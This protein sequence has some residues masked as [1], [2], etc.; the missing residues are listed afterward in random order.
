LDESA[1]L[2]DPGL[3]LTEKESVRMAIPGDNYVLRLREKDGT[4]IHM[5]VLDL[6]HTGPTER[7][8]LVEWAYGP[9]A[10]VDV[11]GFSILR[12]DPLGKI[13]GQ[14]AKTL[15]SFPGLECGNFELET[16]T[17]LP[18]IDGFLL[19][20]TAKNIFNGVQ[21]PFAMRMNNAGDV[22]WARKY[23]ADVGHPTT[24]KI[25]SMV[26]LEKPNF[27][28]S[29]LSSDDET[30]LFQIDGSTGDVTSSRLMSSL[31]IRRLR[32]TSLGVLAVGET[33][34]LLSPE[35]A[36]L[37]LDS[38]TATPIWL[39]TSTWEKP[40]PDSG[41]RWLDIAEGKDVLLVVGN[42]VGHVNEISPWMAFLD[43]NSLPTPADIIKVIVPEL[44][45][46]P[47]R[48]RS[49]VNHQD[50]VIPIKEG[51]VNSIFCVTGD[52][53]KQPWSFAIA[54]DGTVH[55]QKKLLLPEKSEGRQVPIIWPSF[56]EIITGGFA[57][58]GSTSRAFI[59]SSPVINGRGSM[60]CSEETAVTFPKAVLHQHARLPSY[61]PLSMRTLDW[62]SDQG[63]ELDGKKGC[64]N[65]Q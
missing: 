21:H 59:A 11:A 41:V 51:A 34:T 58:T 23:V 33:N 14:F 47:V 43:K 42:A 57:T 8:A 61:D 32:R 5:N 19:A 30:W 56:D 17:L 60:T 20:G 52:L 39:R 29:A 49:V 38:T 64:L 54:E 13:V 9:R 1:P 45:E 65:L 10:T 16:G 53:Q 12:I 7:A 25:T 18:V 3:P 55:W 28:L 31:R 4:L 46:Q 24:A 63:R 48:L 27:L 44:G 36:I 50:I 40:D 15:C 35:P 2:Y 37:A 62:S 6:A 22:R 26:P